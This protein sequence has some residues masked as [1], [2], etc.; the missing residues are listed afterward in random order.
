MATW[1]LPL[2]HNRICSILRAVG[3]LGLIPD[4]TQWF[5]D[6]ALSQLWLR[7]LLCLQ[8][9][10]QELCMLW[11]SQ[12]DKRKKKEECMISIHQSFKHFKFLTHFDR[13]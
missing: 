4:L 6:L 13:N 10:A 9:L 8:S 11:G 3:N 12:N 1:E 5:M 7:L 2:W